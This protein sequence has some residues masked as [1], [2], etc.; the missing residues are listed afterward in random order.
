MKSREDV[1]RLMESVFTQCMATRESGQKEYA[2]AENNALSNFDTQ[3]ND[4]QIDRKKV[5]YIF[6]DKHWRGIRSFI[7]GHKSQ[8]ED[9][10][11]RIKD[12]IVYLILLWA[13]I[14][15]DDATQKAEEKRKLNDGLFSATH[16]KGPSVMPEALPEL[17][18]RCTS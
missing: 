13:M 2:H 16:T 10:R 3:A 9:V 18:P 11:G 12:V 5:W 7:N 4:L 14:D 1:A 6:A 15:D 17:S 8:R